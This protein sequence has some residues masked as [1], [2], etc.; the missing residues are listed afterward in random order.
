MTRVSFPIVQVAFDFPTPFLY[1]TC[2]NCDIVSFG[3]LWGPSPFV[4]GSGERI[5][6][7]PTTNV[8]SSG[9]FGAPLVAAPY[10]PL[11]VR[12]TNASLASYSF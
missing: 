2:N 11:A 3:G 10:Y 5:L 7:A 12:Y 1:G 8:S 6:A 9:L 4:M